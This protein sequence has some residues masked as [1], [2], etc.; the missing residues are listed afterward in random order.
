VIKL[1][2]E[3]VDAVLQKFP[4]LRVILCE[5]KALRVVEVN[6]RLEAFKEEVYARFET[7]STFMG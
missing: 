7:S 4:D 5:V 3:I 2:L 6:L 1:N